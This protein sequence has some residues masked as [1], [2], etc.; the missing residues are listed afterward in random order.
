MYHKP[1]ELMAL[2]LLQYA[3]NAQMNVQL[4]LLQEMSVHHAQA[5]TFLEIMVAFLWPM[6]IAK[7]VIAPDVLHADMGSS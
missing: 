7:P 3:I 2:L 4:V 5:E 1:L 6:L